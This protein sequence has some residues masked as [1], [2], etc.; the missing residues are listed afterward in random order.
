MNR[1]TFLE[2][3]GQIMTLPTAPYHERFVGDAVAE[4]AARRPQLV[5]SSDDFGNLLL[6]Y[7]GDKEETASGGR[8]GRRRPRLVVTAHMD[9]P[10]MA[11]AKRLSGPDFLFE[12]L[13][14]VPEDLS[15]DGKVDIFRL[16]RPSHQKPIRGRIIACVSPAAGGSEFRIRVGRD[17]SDEVGPGSFA[18][19]A[20]RPLEARK[21]RLRARACDDLAG[22]TAGLCFLD[23]LLSRHS[24]IRA[25]LLLTRAEETGLGGML[26]AARSGSLDR[27]ALYVNIEC[28]SCRAGAQ[29][30]AGPVVRVGD[31]ISLFDP[32]ITG[33]LVAVAEELTKAAAGADRP[34]RYQRKLMDGGTC[35]ATVLTRVGYGV[36]AVALPLK[37]YHNAGRNG[38]RPEIIDLDD[39]VWLVELL[40]GVAL[41][42]A[43]VTGAFKAAGKEMDRAIG[44]RQ[45]EQARRL[46][47]QR[48]GRPAHP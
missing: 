5:M 41:H 12:R 30:G 44:A 26:A 3:A 21:R 13:G 35:E 47:R 46:R 31:R 24:P 20:L 37:N 7:D 29:L 34:F 22:V 19:L 25:G 43:G 28:S 6:L 17:D 9:H 45:R 39:A 23:E 36:G 15:R 10:G 38:L 33:G 11:F 27:R 2:L 42:P 4:F 8:R 40:V 18:M 48:S 32:Q 14:G 1:E 16:D